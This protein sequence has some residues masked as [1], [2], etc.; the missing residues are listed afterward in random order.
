MTRVGKGRPSLFGTRSQRVTLVVEGSVVVWANVFGSIRRRRTRSGISESEPAPLWPVTPL[1]A[2]AGASHAVL[3]VLGPTVVAIADEFE[4]SVGLAAQSRSV[5]AG[6]AIVASATITRRIDT[7][8]V[9]RLLTFGAGLAI[10]ACA[11]V[12]LSPTLWLFLASHLIMGLAFACLVSAGFAGVACFRPIRRAWV[13]GYVTAAG[14]FAWIVVNPIVGIVTDAVSWRL[15]FLVPAAIG[16]VTLLLA[17]GSPPSPEGATRV[18]L[19]EVVARSSAR[20]WMSAELVYHVAWG[21]FLTFAG[22]FFIEALGATA[23]TVGWVL[24]LGPA[25]YIVSATQTK[26]FARPSPKSG[27]I[28][29]TAFTMVVLFILL[30]AATG[31]VTVAAGLNAL[32][33]LAAGFRTVLSSTLGMAQLPTHPGAMMSVRTGVT[34]VGY[35]L[36]GVIGGVVISGQGYSSFGLVL[37]SI[38]GLYGLLYLRFSQPDVVTGRH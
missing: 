23:S 35:L 28:A 13:M 15:A 34:Q 7:M 19:R 26:G 38:L 16:L 18:R 14:A 3:V 36:G 20:R 31:S 37:A 2:A 4:T 25:A 12:A 22:A 1:V 33:G 5:T 29:V 17:R 6:I 32:L 27:V 24:A 30:F 8:G 11:A 21:A 10:V 9:R